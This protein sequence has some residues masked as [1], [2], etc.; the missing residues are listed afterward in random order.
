MHVYTSC[1]HASC[2]GIQLVDTLADMLTRGVHLVA[3][4]LADVHF[5]SIYF[6]GID[7]AYMHIGVDE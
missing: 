2:T 5:R 7:L 3:I 1:R 6:V 4:Q